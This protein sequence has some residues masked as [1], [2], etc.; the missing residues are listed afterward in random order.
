MDTGLSKK[1]K[2]NCIYLQNIE[3][4]W[5]NVKYDM[6]HPF[7]PREFS[8]V[9]MLL[10]NPDR[11]QFVTFISRCSEKESQEI[12]CMVQNMVN[13]IKE[14]TNLNTKGVEIGSENEHKFKSLVRT[15]HHILYGDSVS[16]NKYAKNGLYY[17]ICQEEPRAQ[18]IQKVQHA[19][20]S[21]TSSPRP[22][23]RIVEKK[24]SR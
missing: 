3:E 12:S 1:D 6:S 23:H 21:Y 14:M 5:D 18:L 15:W 8:V 22:R 13:A 20:N 10:F 11:K 19:N 7:D 9:T 17:T 4:W 16:D 24:G 2:E